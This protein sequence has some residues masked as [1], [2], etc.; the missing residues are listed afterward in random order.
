MEKTIHQCPNCGAG[1]CQ[2]MDSR[3][4]KNY[5][6]RRRRC[7]DCSKRW[8]TMEI[9]ESDYKFLI[10]RH[11]FERKLASVAKDYVKQLSPKEQAAFVD[12]LFT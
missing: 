3:A 5:V 8:T 10:A 9:K 11:S 12:G 2:V 4:T 1:D 7:K 6:R